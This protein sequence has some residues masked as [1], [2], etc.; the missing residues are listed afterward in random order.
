MINTSPPMR[1]QELE[2]V[3]GDLKGEMLELMLVYQDIQD[4]L[5]DIDRSV[6]TE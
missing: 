5:F 4:K 1:V 3:V 2:E 6:T